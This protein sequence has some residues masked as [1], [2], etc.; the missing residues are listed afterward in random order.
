MFPATIR[1]FDFMLRGLQ[2]VEH[3]LL[4]LNIPFQL[5]Y[6][7][8]KDVVP[9][10]MTDFKSNLLI[11]DFSPLRISRQWLTELYPILTT[12]DVHITQV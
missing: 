2:E 7:A 8:P 6:G 1:A 9:R 5:L 4:L 3:E 11:T 10:F 12:N